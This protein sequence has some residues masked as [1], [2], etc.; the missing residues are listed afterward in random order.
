MWRD[1]Q[2]V[3][4]DYFKTHAPV[5]QWPTIRLALTTILSNNW[6]SKQV[7]YTNAFAQE[8]LR[9]KFI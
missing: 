6:N 5:V 1:I 2:T 8:N 9:K 3:D 4:I 7:D